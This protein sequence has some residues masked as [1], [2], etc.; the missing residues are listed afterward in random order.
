MCH[1]CDGVSEIFVNDINLTQALKFEARHFVNAVGFL[2]SNSDQSR[3]DI[4]LK[5]I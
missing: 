1:R 4:P 2:R 3:I 5:L